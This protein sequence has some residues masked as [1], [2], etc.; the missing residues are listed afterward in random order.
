M[1]KIIYIPSISLIILFS[2]ILSV[3]WWSW[4]VASPWDILVISKWQEAINEI[5]TKM[6]VSDFK[7]WNNTKSTII[8][9][10]VEVWVYENITPFITNSVPLVMATSTNTVLTINWKGFTSWTTATIQWFD[11]TLNSVSIISPLEIQIDLTSWTNIN[12]YN[13]ILN[14]WNKS[15]LDWDSNNWQWLIDVQ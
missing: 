4:L 2:T 12:T 5:N 11:G 15:T 6:K 9:N 14:N 8:W 13:L 10:T 7:D 1:K 3:F